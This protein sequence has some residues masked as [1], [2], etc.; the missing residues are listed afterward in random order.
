MRVILDGAT[1]SLRPRAAFRP[2]TVSRGETEISRRPPVVGHTKRRIQPGRLRDAFT[3]DADFRLE[4][5]NFLSIIS[6]RIPWTES[7]SSEHSTE[8]LV[9]VLGLSST[10]KLSTTMIT[11]WPST[12]YFLFIRCQRIDLAKVARTKPLR[13]EG[14]AAFSRVDCVS[15]VR[16]IVTPTPQTLGLAFER[17]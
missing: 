14:V 17:L 13:G 4:T 1:R 8:T 10:F 12:A 2:V 15:L 3:L 5:W 16:C 6:L 11:L 9:Q 7:A